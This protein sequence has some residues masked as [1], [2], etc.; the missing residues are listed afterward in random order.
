MNK[1]LDPTWEL[2]K[3]DEHFKV[4]VILIV[5]ESP[6]TVYKG[7]EKDWEESEEKSIPSRP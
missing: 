2:K 4:T 3:A 1:H 6:E 5:V 7:L